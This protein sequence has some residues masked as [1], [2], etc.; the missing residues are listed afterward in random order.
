MPHGKPL[1]TLAAL[2][3][4]SLGTLL[5]CGARTPLTLGEGNT[6]GGNASSGSTGGGS[7]G[8]G[9]AGG[10]EGALRCLDAAPIAFTTTGEVN[11][12]ALAPGP[13]CDVFAVGTDFGNTDFAGL[14]TSTSDW[15][16]I[17]VHVQRD[18]LADWMI[19]I[20]SGGDQSWADGADQVVVDEAGR[21]WI[22]GYAG[23]PLTL[24]GQT[25]IG[26]FVLA[27]DAKGGVRWVQQLESYAYDLARKPDGSIAVIEK[28]KGLIEVV[29]DGESGAPLSRLPLFE[30]Q[31]VE[32]LDAV[33]RKAGRAFALCFRGTMQI[34]SL[35]LT[36]SDD[37]LDGNGQVTCDLALVAFDASGALRYAKTFEEHG[38]YPYLA[39]LD[40]DGSGSLFA[41]LS[42]WGS[43]DFGLGPLVASPIGSGMRGLVATFTSDGDVRTNQAFGAGELVLGTGIVAAPTGGFVVSGL[44]YS[45]ELGLDEGNIGSGPNTYLGFDARFAADG[46]L[47]TASPRPKLEALS[48]AEP[49]LAL[50][51]VRTPDGETPRVI[52]VAREV[53]IPN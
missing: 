40:L 2:V 8:G 51:I 4:L 43:V 45:A 20:A 46:D 1:T 36:A 19:P 31:D 49:G 14:T 44:L 6:G 37:T 9:D 39:R 12:A 29:L 16:G 18:G 35:T 17:I 21:A 27:V 38:F 5:G 30:G 52:T 11:L 42:F 32:L 23:S 48:A 24:G 26:D 33:T 25:L 13:S 7:T 53:I 22:H 28:E 3:S 15:N 50:S 34:G 10:G 41:E 47:L